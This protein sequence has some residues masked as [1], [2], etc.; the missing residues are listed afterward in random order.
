MRRIRLAH[1]STAFLCISPA[2]RLVSASLNRLGRALDL[3]LR[4]FVGRGRPQRP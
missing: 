4:A 3:G 2:I 1:A